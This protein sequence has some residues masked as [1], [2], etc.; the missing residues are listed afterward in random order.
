MNADKIDTSKVY[1]LFEE[2]KELVKQR[3]N[4]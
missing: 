2:I 1:T 3:N 4:K